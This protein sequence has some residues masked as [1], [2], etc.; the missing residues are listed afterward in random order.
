MI[1]KSRDFVICSRMGMLSFESLL[2]MV[3][4]SI[5]LTK[6]HV[7]ICDKFAE[8]NGYTGERKKVYVNMLAVHSKRVRAVTA[9]TELIAHNKLSVVEISTS[10]LIHQFLK[11]ELFF[12]NI[13]FSGPEKLDKNLL[14]NS[15]KRVFLKFSVHK[16]YRLF[17]RRR[18][19]TSA[20]RSW[21]EIS[22]NMYADVFPSSTILIYPFYLNFSRHIKYI[23]Y[24]FKCFNKVTLSGLPYSLIDIC[25]L[26]FSPK[27]RDERLVS[28]EIKAY[29]RHADE[30]ASMGL[31]NLYTCD[32]FEAASIAMCSKLQ[33]LNVHITNTAHGLGFDCPYVGYDIFK[34]YNSSQKEYYYH[35]SKTTNFSISPR[36]NADYSETVRKIAGKITIIFI[37]ANFERLGLLYE[38]KLESDAIRKLAEISENINVSLLIKAHPNRDLSS[39]K[40][41]E[42]LSGIKIFRRLN[43]IENIIPIFVTIASAAYYDFRHLGPF[44]FVKDGYTDLE[45]FYGET[46]NS[47]SLEQLEGAIKTCVQ[48]QANAT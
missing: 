32:E 14:S 21:V 9:L 23:R 24:C 19:T 44:L 35:K 5:F 34:V 4:S 11:N 26:F 42:L 46:V 18:K 1:K 13:G 45:K 22:Q 7:D 38:A 30:L 15:L 8:L 20:I 10:T 28:F 25:G 37:E 27:T 40:E 31:L 48:R 47:Y 16:L 2:S 17:F 43:E 3:P 36:F 39:Y 12:S 6:K 29:R 33:Q 41:K